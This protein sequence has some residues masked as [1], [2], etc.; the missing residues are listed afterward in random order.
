M[1]QEV[2]L[3][4]S[5]WQSG[6]LSIR[7][8]SSVDGGKFMSYF[9][10]SDK[11][12]GFLTG[13]GLSNVDLYVEYDVTL[14]EPQLGTN[15]T[16]FTGDLLSAIPTRIGRPFA[17]FTAPKTFVLAD[18]YYSFSGYFNGTGIVVNGWNATNAVIRH[19]WAKWPD[20]AA[21]T[22]GW[23]VGVIDAS[24]AG[25]TVVTI[26]FTATSIARSELTIV[27]ISKA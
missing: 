16:T 12:H 7:P 21:A 4:M 8:S 5:L 26:N 18:G 14:S 3:S 24:A 10:D 15:G 19:H 2:S 20:S 1:A 11:D 17:N 22:E 27:P 23:V 9:P 25:N 13:F 6:S